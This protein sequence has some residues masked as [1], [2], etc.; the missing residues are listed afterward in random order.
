[1]QRYKLT[2]I[3]AGILAVW[4]FAPQTQ[5]QD[6]FTADKV[7]AVVGRSAILYSEIDK[8]SKALVA[9]RKEQGYTSER[10]PRCEVLEQQI[11]QKL[12]YNQSQIDSLEVPMD[13]IEEIVQSN[14]DDEIVKYGSVAALE[15]FYHK[16]IFSVREELRNR[17]KESSGASEMENTIRNKVHITPGEV[18]KF[19]KSLPKDSLPIIP[20]Q[21]VYSQIV[22]Y[23][24]NVEDAKLRTKERLLELRERIL[25]GAK[26]DMLARTYSQDPQSAIRG[27]DMGLSSKDI[28]VPP[29]A[30]AL[31]KL[32][33]GQVSG[34]VETMYGFHLI[35]LIDKIGNQYH[36]SH[37]LLKPQYTD[38]DLEEPYDRLDSVQKLI[39]AGKLT[40]E[41][42]VTENSEDKYSKQNGGLVSNLEQLEMYNIGDP[43]EASTKFY[44]EYLNPEDYRVL[45]KLKPGE[46]STPFASQDMLQNLLCKIVRLEEVIPAHPADLKE[47]YLQIERMA[48]ADKQN[49]AFVDWLKE[50][51]DGMYI[52]IDDEF[53]NC[54]FMY[55]FLL[56]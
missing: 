30:D 44:T 43:T 10:D 4:S 7:V 51:A 50:K 24:S 3:A 55:D 29:F 39:V 27:G 32:K 25:N 56:K 41:E 1:M 17:Y 18:E 14:L 2:A 40:F 9:Q 36:V 38:K 28:F 22:R 46:V 42:A 31:S 48:L 19:Y 8:Y 23:P 34:V 53:R 49:K 15:M 35:Q 54:D 6:K 5:A 11:I 45:Q 47:D 16:P 20:E 21:Y 37:I 52:R 12:L 33:P 13:R 26:F